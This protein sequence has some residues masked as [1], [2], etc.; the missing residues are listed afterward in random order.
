MASEKV[1]VSS[2]F[3]FL[4]KM[5]YLKGLPQYHTLSANLDYEFVADKIISLVKM[6]GTANKGL[7][8]G[9]TNSIIIQNSVP[10]LFSG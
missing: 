2:Y 9:P 3:L 5:F 10:P 6:S 8:L 4:Y 7:W 1:D